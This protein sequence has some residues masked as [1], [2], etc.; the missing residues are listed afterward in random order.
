MSGCDNDDCRGTEGLV[1][2]PG[3]Q[4]T[5]RFRVG[6]GGSSNNLAGTDERGTSFKQERFNDC[7]GREQ[8][9]VLLEIA[10][11][12]PKKPMRRERSCGDEREGRR[13]LCKEPRYTTILTRGPRSTDKT[14][15]ADGLVGTDVSWEYSELPIRDWRHE[16]R[17]G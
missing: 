8:G 2:V 16:G 7:D 17:R 3:C 5:S 10:H 13:T 4:R 9:M 14:G 12:Q 11:V 15:L 6:A 1:S